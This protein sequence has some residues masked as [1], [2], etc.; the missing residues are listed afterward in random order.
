MSHGGTVGTVLPPM[1]T[2]QFVP[3]QQNF[4]R[5]PANDR[6][7]PACHI[8][9]VVA[10][11]TRQRKKGKGL[12]KSYF[13]LLIAVFII[14]FK[15][16][17]FL[18]R[19]SL[20]AYRGMIKRFRSAELRNEQFNTNF[21][22]PFNTNADRMQPVAT[23]PCQKKESFDEHDGLPAWHNYTGLCISPIFAS[24]DVSEMQNSH[25]GHIG[26]AHVVSMHRW[27]ANIT[28]SLVI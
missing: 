26:H 9:L 2:R 1:Q 4:F 12:S 8:F 7:P 23:F 27:I 25:R 15:T 24:G 19:G 14:Q 16:P 11:S 17:S 5:P 18:T 20:A 13:T 10:E 6:K 28:V 3:P 21:S 22:E